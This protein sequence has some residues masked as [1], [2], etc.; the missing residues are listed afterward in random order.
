MQHFLSIDIGASS[1]RH[2]LGRIE[3]GCLRTREIYRFPNGAVRKGDALCWPIDALA[4]HVE[5]GLR[6]CGE[7]GIVP[8]S[9]GI[10]TWAVDFVLLDRDKKLIGD[11]V[12]YRDSRTA[13]MDREVEKVIPLPEL[14][15]RTGI[16]KQVFNTIYQ[17]MA[18]KKQ[19]PDCLARAAYFLMIPD[20]LNFLLTGEIKN[21]Y[22]NATTTQLVKAGT[23]VWDME[24]IERL[25]LPT[26]IFQEILMPGTQL[27]TLTPEMQE[28][29]GFNCKVVVPATHDTGSA[30][31]AV[32]AQGGDFLYISSGTWSLL[33]TEQ[34]Q[35]VCTPEAQ[36]ANL[37]NEGGYAQRYRLLKN[38]MGSWMIQ[39]VRNETGKIHSFDEL[40]EMA[41]SEKDFPSVL[42]VN[43]A[44][45]LAPGNMQDAVREYCRRT[46]QRVPETLSQCMSC[47]YRSLAIGYA[48]AARQ[49]CEVTGRKFQQM[50]IVGG[51][52]KDW[53]LNQLAARQL[54]IPVCAGPVEATA[55]GN[56]L[57][58]MLHAGVFHDLWEARACVRG[59]FQI[60]SVDPE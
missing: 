12:A 8:E 58:Q 27:G 54:G 31:L 51:G 24:L 36:A 50:Y 10:D 52:S 5:D 7:M 38:I 40:C 48:E 57:A 39:S 4:Q 19:H 18:L 13:G 9:V 23:A 42:D 3:D 1:G 6:A 53:Y 44:I 37:T 46:K 47:I 32:P 45:F 55:I 28:K 16:Q 43:D 49:I 22:T 20:Y 29:V 56:L 17:L 30:V 15:A 11:A 26:H 14:Y 33:G 35:A 34:E 2:I 25:G 60:Q 59:S 41:E 21:E